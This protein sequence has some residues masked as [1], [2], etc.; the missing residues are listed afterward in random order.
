[1]TSTGTMAIGGSAKI[2]MLMPRASRS[3][4]GQRTKR[5]AASDRDRI[6]DD[7]ADRGGAHG[8]QD[9][10]RSSRPGPPRS[11]RGSRSAPAARR[12]RRGRARRRSPRATSNDE[13]A[14]GIAVDAPAS[15]PARRLQA[16]A[17]IAASAEQRAR[18][19]RSARGTRRRGRSS[20]AAAARTG[21]RRCRRSRPGRPPSTTTRSARNTASS[22]P[23]VTSSVVGR[24]SIQ[25]R[26]SSMFICRRRI[27]S[28]AP[29]GSSMS[30]TSGSVTSERAMA[31]R[32]RM[33]PESSPGSACSK[34]SRPTR[35]TRSGMRGARLAPVAAEHVERQRDI[36]ARPSA[37]AGVPRPG[38]RCR[39]RR[40]CRTASGGS[41]PIST[42]AA[43]RALSSPR[44]IRR[45]VDLPQP[46][47]PISAVNEPGGQS[48][49]TR[50]RTASGLPRTRKRLRDVVEDDR[51]P[52]RHLASDLG[53][54]RRVEHLAGRLDADLAERVDVLL[55]CPPRPS[56]RCRSGDSISGFWAVLK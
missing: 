51:A 32:W 28:S 17:A 54:E 40:G 37:R 43:R 1:M 21:R 15:R 31:T 10:R 22:M 45:S 5:I 23:W 52:A 26:C 38:R 48:S 4:S 8:R 18:P 13:R 3:V 20:S 42:R 24:R 33:P 36:G 29:K 6:A 35:R 47:G 27:R 50:S 14:S 12:R 56:R 2:A 30:R 7:E 53:E 41:P 49:E 46:D 55:R 39:S 34:P 16:P 9:M 25:M 11:G 19:C 44:A